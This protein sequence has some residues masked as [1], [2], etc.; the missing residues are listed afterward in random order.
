MDGGFVFSSRIQLLARHPAVE[1][2]F[3]QWYLQE[4]FAFGRAL[5]TRTPLSG[6][7]KLSPASRT[8]VDVSTG[9]YETEVYWRPEYCPLDR[10]YS[11]FVREFAD[12]FKRVVDDRTQEDAEYGVLMSGWIDSR[13]IPAALDSEATGYHMNEWE[14]Q[15]AE[16]TRMVTEMA[17]H[18]F[19]FLL[20]SSIDLHSVYTGL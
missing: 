8:C 6:I 15:E 9:E 1:T 20:F 13:I 12:R 2:A 3:E 19:E 16:I 5:G 18:D 11:E 7:E 14:N 10:P 4:Y 17:G